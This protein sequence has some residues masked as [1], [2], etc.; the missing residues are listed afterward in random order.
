MFPVSPRPRCEQRARSLLCQHLLRKTPPK[1]AP[2]LA[3]CP[4]GKFFWYLLIVFLTLSYYT[5]YGMVSSAIGLLLWPFVPV[6]MAAG[7]KPAV[8]S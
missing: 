5:Y 1:V 3:S 2:T 4:A 8:S 7:C 6:L